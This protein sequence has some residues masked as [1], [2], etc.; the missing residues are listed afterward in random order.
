MKNFWLCFVPLFFAVDAIGVLP[1]FMSLTPDIEKGK[2]RKII[3]QSVITAT[4]VSVLFLAAGTAVLK[5]LG[6]TM[7]DFMIAGG[8]LLFAI[9]MSDLLTTE[10]IQRKIDPESPGAVPLGVPLISGPALLTTSI[11]LI[12]EHGF[13]ITATAI[14]VM[15]VRKGIMFFIP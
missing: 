15:I 7:A 12:N 2:I 10:K 11:L 6:I 4:L 9:A 5:H 8:I 14:A 13:I 1:L 3:I